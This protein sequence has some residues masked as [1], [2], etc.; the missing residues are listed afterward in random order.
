[1]GSSPL[2][3]I[4]AKAEKGIRLVSFGLLLVGVKNFVARFQ[5][6]A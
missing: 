2:L 4:S 5:F 3:G 1:M 6:V